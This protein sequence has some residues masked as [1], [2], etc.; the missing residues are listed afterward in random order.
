M[1]LLNLD[2][3]SVIQFLGGKIA[4]YAGMLVVI[5]LSFF[6]CKKHGVSKL[7]TLLFIL[8]GYTGG[9]Y[10]AGLMGGLYTKVAAMYGGDGSKQAIFGVVVGLP[11]FL[12]VAAL[13]TG[14]DWRSIT[15]LFAPGAFL[16]LAFSKFGCFLS[17]CCPGIE[18]KFGVYNNILDKVM[19]PSQLCES[20]TMVFVVA[21]SF[22]YSLRYEKRVRGAA[23]PVTAMLYTFTRFCWEFL[24][25]YDIDKMKH[26][27]F[28]LS[29]WQ[30]WCIIVF[31]AS[32]F[33][34]RLLKN[35]KLPEVEEKYYTFI[36]ARFDA[37]KGKIKS[38]LPQ[39]TKS[40]EDVAGE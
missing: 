29:F 1:D 16:G 2:Q 40:A 28:G 6:I 33:W 34:L 8:T 5:I 18:C 9:V 7:S 35:P 24:R 23:Y 10:F 11:I 19:F 4:L 39:K 25:Y 38:K 22:W 20:I 36:N 31:V 14:H 32:Y 3:Y 17:G 37:F 12:I 30:I 26:L 15:D 27:L 13:L 21:F